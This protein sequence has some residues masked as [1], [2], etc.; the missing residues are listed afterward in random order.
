MRTTD[1][2]RRRHRHWRRAVAALIAAAAVAAGCGSQ[3]HTEADPVDIEQEVRPAE[4]ATRPPTAPAS[5][6]AATMPEFLDDVL[7]LVHGYWSETFAA[8]GLDA[9]TVGHVWVAPGQQ[10]ESACGPVTD[11][12][13]AYCPADDTMYIGQQFAFDL[14]SGT[15]P[16]NGSGVAI[17]DFGLAEVVAHE[18][19]HNVQHE[20]GL[21][22]T[23]GGPV[24]PVEL[25]ADCLAGLWANSAYRRGLLE[26][27]DLEE[28]L[29]TIR[30]VG[31]FNYADPQHH[32]T[33]EER[34]TAW[35]AGYESGDPS[36]CAR[37]A[38]G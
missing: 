16:S 2:R 23:E 9:P 20:L 24:K 26:R 34:L 3:N 8:A 30:S 36:T 14:W 5:T 1:H 19:G 37:A 38:Q 12:D 25:Q 7:G 28:A 33:P 22:D 17:G 13:A 35:L 6:T 10:L 11:Q 4:T 15:T 32:G 29:D 21:D 18:Y 31:D 27:G